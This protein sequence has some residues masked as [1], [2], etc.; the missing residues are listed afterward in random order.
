MYELFLALRYL[1]S[2]HRRRFARATAL[3][4]ILGIAAGVGSLIVAMALANGFRDEM[5]A[6]ILRGTAHLSVMRVDGLSMVN[7]RDLSARVKEIK[8][9]SEAQGTTFHPAMLI[10]PRGSA[11]S[12][13]RGVD[14]SSAHAQNELAEFVVAGKLEPILAPTN[15]AAE[16]AMVLLGEELARRTGLNSG[17]IGQVV[18]AAPDFP[19]TPVKR[20]V[21]VSGIFRSGLFEY[22]STWIYLSLDA[23]STLTGTPKSASII[24][25]QLKDPYEVK[26]VAAEIERSLGKG[27]STVDWQEAN[28]PLFTA[29]DLERRMG[30]IVLAL[31]IFL[32]TLNITSTLILV[33]TERRRDIGIL[34]AMGA[35]SRSIMAIF[36]I[37]GAI[38]GSVGAGLGIVLGLIGCVLGNHYKLVSLPPDVYSISYVPFNSHIR[39]VGLAALVAFTLSL[40]ATIYPARAA[41]SL[42]PGEILSDE[43]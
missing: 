2:R 10:G 31:I 29:L 8:G 12:L 34:N 32:A 22:D 4:A 36:I 35:T 16:P 20:S 40:L 14:P 24:S 28:R 11:Y 38:L 27:Y 41:A 39:D 23:A 13:L 43:S 9:V 1:G 37:E 5:R 42:R 19:V 6:K 33:V 18:S 30:L 21:H 3:F 25:V 7:Y 15:E 26:Q 17:D